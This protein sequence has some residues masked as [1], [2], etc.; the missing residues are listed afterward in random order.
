M[1][2]TCVLFATVLTSKKSSD[3]NAKYCKE[4][5]FVSPS[6][7]SYKSNTAEN[8]IKKRINNQCPFSTVL[9]IR[10]CENIGIIKHN[11]DIVQ[12]VWG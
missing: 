6:L 5:Q 8:R 11:R 9:H 3:K 1:F 4:A 7:C 10:L 2:Y 12:N